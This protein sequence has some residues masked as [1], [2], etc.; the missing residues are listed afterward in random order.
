MVQ[1]TGVSG[2]SRRVWLFL[3]CTFVVTW[4]AWWLLAALT[5]AGALTPTEPLGFGLL[6]LGGTAPTAAAYLAVWRTPNAGSVRAFNRRVFHLRVPPGLLFVAVFGA[7]GLGIVSL[8]LTGL[9]FGASWS[10]D[11]GRI[12]LLFL[13]AFAPSILFGGLEE[14]GWRGVLQPAV[15]DRYNLVVANLV[16]A[17]VWGVWHLPRFWVVGGSH[18]GGSFLIFLVAGVGYSAVMTWL[19]A[20]TESIAL[21]VVF[22]AGINASVTAGLAFPVDQT[23]GFT[24]QAALLVT[25]G[26]VLLAVSAR[27]SHGRTE[28]AARQAARSSSPEGR[29]E[30][31]SPNP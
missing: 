2:P 22:H 16:I 29:P 18:P 8:G 31:G 11:P 17:G 21:C 27:R 30:R 12:V 4:G 23:P 9:I 14:V 20:R 5:I 10:A 25:V 7:A 24:V 15:T 6:V 13:V 19:Y 1:T 28:T 26:T 3:G